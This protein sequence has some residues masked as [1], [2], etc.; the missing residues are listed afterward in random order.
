MS[1]DGGSNYGGE[2]NDRT[3]PEELSLYIDTLYY[4]PFA[5]ALCFTE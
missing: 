4:G 5:I 3:F 1:E 2:N